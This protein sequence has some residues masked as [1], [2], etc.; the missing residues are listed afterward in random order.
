M[1]YQN[2]TIS[3]ETVLTPEQ[4]KKV[5]EKKKKKWDLHS[6]LNLT[7]IEN[8]KDI[9]YI[10]FEFLKNHIFFPPKSATSESQNLNFE[11]TNKF[12]I[13]LFLSFEK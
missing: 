13:D 12:P 4:E 2:L 6:A 11:I 10:K 1:M 9:T 8:K 5:L 3:T 7:W